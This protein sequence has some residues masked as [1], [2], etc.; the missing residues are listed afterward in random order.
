MNVL[1]HFPV[2]KLILLDLNCIH[3]TYESTFGLN[4]FVQ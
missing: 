2:E 4:L 1:D 3:S